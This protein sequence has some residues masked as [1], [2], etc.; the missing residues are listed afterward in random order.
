MN[1][2]NVSDQP[3]FFQHLTE[4]KKKLRDAQS[5]KGQ[6]PPLKPGRETIMKFHYS[7]MSRPKKQDAAAEKQSYLS[8]SFVPPPYPLYIQPLSAL[9]KI[10][11]SDLLLETHHRGRYLVLRTVTPQDRLHGVMAI[12]EDERGD[13][14]LLQ[15][16]HQEETGAFEDIFVQG[17][18]VIATAETGFTAA[19]WKTKGNDCFNSGKLRG[20]IECYTR[21]LDCSPTAN[22]QTIIKLNRALVFLRSESF[23]AALLDLESAM[24]VNTKLTDKSLFRQ[25]QAFYGLLRYRECCDVLKTLRQAYPDNAAAKTQLDRAICRLTEQTHGRYKFKQLYAE[26][27]QLRPPYLDHAT[28][29][30]PVCVRPSGIG[31]RGLFTT[32]AVA[33]GD[34]LLCE[35]AFAYAFVDEDGEKGNTRDISVLIDPVADTVTM[36]AHPELIN[37]TIR[38]MYRNP[39]LASAVTHLHRGT[40]E[41]VD[42]ASVDGTPVLD[43]FLVRR[44]IALNVFGCPLTSRTSYLR[45]ITHTLQAQNHEFHS[46]GLWPTASY[47]NH[48]C[49]NNATRAFIG[50]MMFVRATRNIPPDTE[51]TWWYAP[52]ADD[53]THQDSLRKT[54]GF[55]CRCALC[56]DQQ[57][58]PNSVLH[59]CN[60]L[61]REFHRLMETLKRTGN[62]DTKNAERVLAA[63]AATYPRPPSEVPRLS[64]WRLQL[65]MAG[66]FAQWVQPLKTVD[67]ALGA[68]ASLGYVVEGGVPV[69]SPR[70]A[71]GSSMVMVREWGVMV[72]DVIDCWMFLREA[73]LHLL[74]PDLAAGAEG[75]ARIAYRV[76]FGEDETFDETFGDKKPVLG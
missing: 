15:L 75:Y 17:G 55:S 76:Y 37:M 42:S 1:T 16:Y 43:S 67:Y 53:M 48:G 29:I 46:C 19:A 23:N 69:P 11:I 39:S 63:A 22:E 34:L 45:N 50:D 74:A 61:R 24:T 65:T 56:V 36:G 49:T 20:A 59:R 10:M 47:I 73:Y 14:S 72:V 70:R 71:V 4:Q 35:K 6:R 57:N 31:G 5:L 13:V 2:H 54:W 66:V 52:P 12:V 64:L 41:P 27:E 68:L 30:G 51:L 44:I 3:Q 25:A 7:L 33:A 58:T 40:Y 21:A 60:A 32:K 8:T 26:A 28:Y 9:T 18:A 38:K 62:R